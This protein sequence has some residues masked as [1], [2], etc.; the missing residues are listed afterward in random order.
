MAMQRA[1]YITIWDGTTEVHTGCLIDR[2][3]FPPMVYG[4]ENPEQFNQ[5][6]KCN[7]EYVE[8]AD[9]YRLYDFSFDKEPF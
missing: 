7:E 1:T 8:L 4:I 5:Y 3:Q 6:R 9:G 2:T